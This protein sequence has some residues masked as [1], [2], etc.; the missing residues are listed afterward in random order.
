[1]AICSQ[2]DLPPALTC[3][4]LTYDQ[5]FQGDDL[6]PFVQPSSCHCSYDCCRHV[7]LLATWFQ[8]LQNQT[9]QIAE[10]W[11][12]SMRLSLFEELEAKGSPLYKIRDALQQW[13]SDS[14]DATRLWEATEAWRDLGKRCVKDDTACNRIYLGAAKTSAEI[15]WTRKD[16][17]FDYRLAL[18]SNNGTVL[19][20]FLGTWQGRH[21]ETFWSFLPMEG[22]ALEGHVFDFMGLQTSITELPQYRMPEQSLQRWGAL[23]PS[24]GLLR[25]WPVMD[26]EYLEWID[27]LE[28]ARASAGQ[29]QLAMAEVGVVNGAWL[30]RGAKAWTRMLGNFGTVN[31]NLNQRCTLVGVDELPREE[32]ILQ[33][34]S[35]NLPGNCKVSVLS[36][37]LGDPGNPKLLDLLDAATSSSVIWDLLDLDCQG[38]ELGVISLETSK[39]LQRARRLH[40]STH[41]RFI[42]QEVIQRLRETGWQIF[43][44]YLPRSV[45]RSD[46]YGPIAM[47]DGHVSA[48]S[49]R[50]HWKWCRGKIG[51][52]KKATNW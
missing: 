1:M 33:H 29:R 41:S 26:E 34:L 3:W 24:R 46:V 23:R 7:S 52:M 22:P 48:I 11:A 21:H 14:S 10:G 4:Q 20:P 17:R 18:R 37:R 15:A 27:V 31:N 13:P 9:L 19:N 5:M 47:D 25:Q 35:K 45:G 6:P 40:I 38:C 8:A 16:F 44:H 2:F 50:W 42:H 49:T 32:A 36:S 43:T 30:A 12:W 39:L 51:E 28:S